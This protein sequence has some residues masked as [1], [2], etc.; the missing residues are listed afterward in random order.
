[1]FAD[2]TNKSS[3]K[4]G[5]PFNSSSVN[6]KIWPIFPGPEP[7]RRFQNHGLT[8]LPLSFGKWGIVNSPH[9]CLHLQT[10][11]D[12]YGMDHY[13]RC[14]LGKSPCQFLIAAVEKHIFASCLAICLVPRSTGIESALRSTSKSKFVILMSITL[15]L[16]P[17]RRDHAL[18]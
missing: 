7:N 8:N 14:L 13:F 11:V 9:V 5:K 18:S 1:M 17:I 6:Y 16:T 3:Y 15:E 12:S 4:A 2:A 10:M